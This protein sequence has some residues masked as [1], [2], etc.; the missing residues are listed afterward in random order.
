M[1]QAKV[2]TLNALKFALG[3]CG[4]DE[5]D[6][7]L[8]LKA[9]GAGESFFISLD[10]FSGIQVFATLGFVYFFRKKVNAIA[11]HKG[12][13]DCGRGKYFFK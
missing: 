1:Y 3:I 9:N 11:R 8:S 12:R 2:P 10:I 7:A 4:R 5:I 13:K 6:K